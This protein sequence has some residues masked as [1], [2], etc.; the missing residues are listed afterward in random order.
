MFSMV[1]VP[2]QKENEWRP[3]LPTR[4]NADLM[5]F[6]AK[7]AAYLPDGAVC[8]EIG[9]A[10][11][12]S[13][14]YLANLFLGINK[15]RCLLYGIDPWGKPQEPCEGAGGFVSGEVGLE[16]LNGYSTEL[17][18]AMIRLIG[19]PSVRAA[20]AF[21]DQ[22]LDLVMIDGDHTYD[23]CRNDIL[24]YLPKVKPGGLLCGHDYGEQYPGVRK[25]VDEVLGRRAHQYARVW[26]V[27]YPEA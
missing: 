9:I 27:E 1:N 15:R 11:G 12:R 17:E 2:I 5:C 23:G 22:S 6:Y 18:A 19:L 7:A 16:F 26:W 13:L 25:A 8:A 10:Y 20:R 4:D 21:E 14:L 24:A 3:N